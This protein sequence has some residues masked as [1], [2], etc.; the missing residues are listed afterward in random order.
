LVTLLKGDEPEVD[1]DL[2]DEV[3]TPIVDSSPPDD[4]EDNRIDEV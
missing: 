1:P 2:P 4:D 3:E